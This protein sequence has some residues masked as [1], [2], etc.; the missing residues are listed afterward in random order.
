MQRISGVKK[1][2]ITLLA[3]ALSG[4]FA[5]SGT[6][7]AS[8]ATTTC[9]AGTCTVTFS[10]TGNDESWTV[11]YSGDFTLEVWG[12]QGGGG[13]LYYGT[14]GAG[15]Y[16]K[17]T[18]TLSA[19]TVLHVNVGQV[20]AIS[21]TQT[22]YNGGGKGDK[23]SGSGPGGGG[24]GATHIA[25]SF[26]Q[27]YVLN[28]NK[29]AVLIVAGGGGG[30]GGSNQ[31]AYAAY[32]ANGGYGGGTT[33]G[34]GVNGNNEVGTY[35]AGGS[36][37]TQSAGGAFNGGSDA[38]IVIASFGQGGSSSTAIQNSISGGGGGGGWYGGGAA[39]DGGGSGGGG[40]GYVGT[41][42]NS[43]ITAGNAT[44]PN[45]A[46]GTMTGRTGA[47]FARITYTDLSDSSI[48]ISSTS[49]SANVIYRTA[50]TLTAT[51]SNAGRVT[52]YANGKKIGGCVALL[53]NTSVDCLYKASV[54]G[55]QTITAKLTPTSG[56][57]RNSISAPLILLVS[58][59]STRR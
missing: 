35:R 11:P 4:T 46:G 10:Y 37:G 29:T 19:G 38:T 23:A 41:L 31:S 12:A 2:L 34:N 53:A 40:S 42:A 1:A 22:S 36:G 3:V 33:G 27:L 51:V 49:G 6:N 54:K 9:S 15:G 5:F 56:A 43:V 59:R 16:S 7:Q 25:T 39:A 20:G 57:F 30:A 21:D 14:G 48:S 17:G 18:A 58:P 24:G 26:G 50:A 32:A 47:G 28:S 8:A 45:P 52:F 13:G 55:A 44:M